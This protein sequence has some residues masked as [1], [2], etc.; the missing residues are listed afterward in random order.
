MCV[1]R[2]SLIRRTCPTR[3]G[4]PPRWTRRRGTCVSRSPTKPR[5]SPPHRSCESADSAL[6]S[7]CAALDALAE[8]SEGLARCS[9][10]ARTAQ[11]L[12]ERWRDDSR[13]DLVRWVEV[14]SHSLRLNATPLSI[15]G[16]FRRQLDGHPRGW[17]FASATLAVA[18]DFSHYRGEM[19][20][21]NART[22]CWDSPFDYA[23]QALLYVP[24][25]LPDPNSDEHTRAVVAASLP[26]IRAGGGRAFLLF[27]TLRAMRLAP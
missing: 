6:R 2:R 24:K 19:G 22:A 26:V 12:L 8:R 16:I 3:R 25:K 18:G 14:F 9:E 5:A 7:V 15:A 23:A 4:S 10:R 27:T 17:I 20:L 21:D 11:A 13:A 1:R